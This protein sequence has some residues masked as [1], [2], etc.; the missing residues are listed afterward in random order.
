MESAKWVGGSQLLDRDEPAFSE[1]LGYH[2][3]G[4][5]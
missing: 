5:P 1:R 4:D 3:R 2:N